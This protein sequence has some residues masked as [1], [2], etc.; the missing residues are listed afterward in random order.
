MP[1]GKRSDEAQRRREERGQKRR[2]EAAADRRQAQ[3]A[4]DE[5]ESDQ[6]FQ[7][8]TSQPVTLIPR[9]SENKVTLL[10]RQTPAVS[11]AEPTP[12]D[13]PAEIKCEV[14][15]KKKR[16]RRKV[17]GRVLLKSKPKLK[18]KPTTSEAAK[19]LATLKPKRK[20][21]PSRKEK[22]PTTTEVE[23]SCS[24]TSPAGTQVESEDGDSRT[25]G[26]CHADYG[27]DDSESPN[28]DGPDA[29]RQRGC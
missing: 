27:G 20:A 6:E 9:P 25:D 22:Y 13:S 28:P 1:R 7:E 11:P 23:S 21:A 8:G 18:A 12:A 29:K 19:V 5:G 4:G 16:K 2:A 24:P 14:E 15:R 26:S 17:E 10:P 3:E